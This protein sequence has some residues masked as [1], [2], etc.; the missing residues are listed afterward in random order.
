MECS[1]TYLKKMLQNFK[2]PENGMYNFKIQ[3]KELKNKSL[4]K[5]K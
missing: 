3:G 5:S 4:H 1:S 2:N